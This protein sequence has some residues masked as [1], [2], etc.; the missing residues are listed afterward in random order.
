MATSAAETTLKAGPIKDILQ[1]SVAGGVNHYLSDGNN[2]SHE[3]T[4]WFYRADMSVT[5]RKFMLAF[6]IQSNWNWFWGENVYG[7][8]NY[9]ILQAKY[10][11]KK[12]SVGVGVFNPFADNYK[13]VNEN[14]SQYAS[15]KRINYINE[16]SRMVILQFSWNLSFGRSYQSTQKKLNNSDN[17]SGVISTGK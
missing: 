16:S 5:Y 4:N 15:V 2:Y 14:W 12:F 6:Q 1:M 9:H 7:G 3:Y 13:Q 11:H 10:N 17:D 8:E